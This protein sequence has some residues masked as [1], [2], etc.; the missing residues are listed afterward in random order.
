M[1]PQYWGVPKMLIP[2]EKS[3][4]KSRVLLRVGNCSVTMPRTVTVCPM[5]RGT[6]LESLQCSVP[7]GCRARATIGVA[8]TARAANNVR[9]VNCMGNPLA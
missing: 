8:A 9:R 6:P 7:I 1:M 3:W 4:M 2:P 5:V